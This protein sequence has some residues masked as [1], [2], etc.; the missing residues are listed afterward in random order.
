MSS[1][2]CPYCAA[3]AEGDWSFCQ[4][5]GRKLPGTTSGAM[6]QRDERVADLW[7]KAMHCIELCDYDDAEAM[8]GELADVGCDSG[9][10]AALRGAIALRQ[11]RLEEAEEL[12]DRAV[13]ESPHS[14]FVR[15]KRAEYWKTLG[16]APRAIE[17]V[18]EALRYAESER[19][20]QELRVTLEKLKKDSRWNF[21]RAS[22]V[23]RQ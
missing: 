14:P 21:S 13:Q 6:E 9:D 18:T 7:R 11:V 17:E 22:P 19:V 20:R 2:Y 15:V 1:R 3:S 10:L 8:A 12:L 5:C 4:A 23:G 16:M